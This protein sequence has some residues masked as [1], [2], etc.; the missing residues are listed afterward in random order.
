MGDVYPYETRFEWLLH[1]RYGHLLRA[2]ELNPHGRDNLLNER[3]TA[4][5]RWDRVRAAVLVLLYL[6]AAGT[7]VA[8]AANFLPALGEALPLLRAATRVAGALTGLLTLAYLLLTRLLSQLEMDILM[9][10]ANIG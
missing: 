2:L 10:L 5:R 7:A 9:I 1:S 4:L 8:Y 3:A 6:G